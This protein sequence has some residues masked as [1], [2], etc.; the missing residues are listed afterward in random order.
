MI[1]TI[2]IAVG[3]QNYNI[4]IKCDTGSFSNPKLMNICKAINPIRGF[5]INLIIATPIIY[6]LFNLISLSLFL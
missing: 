2:L 4:I 5:T 6:F 3:E 1:I